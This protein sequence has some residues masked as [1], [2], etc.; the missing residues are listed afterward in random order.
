MR[1]RGAV[2]GSLEH[3]LAERSGE[4]FA[5][6]REHLNHQLV[7]I[8]QLTG[9]DRTYVSGS[10]SWLVDADGRRYLD[11]LSGF[12]TFALGRN[13]P[14]VKDALIEALQLD[15]PNLVQLDTPLPAGLL[16]ERLCDLAGPGL[17]RCFFGNSG[18]EAVE[19]AVK[20]A[21]RHTGRRRVLFCDHAFH[22][23]TTGALALNGGKDFRAGFGPLLPGTTR[24]PYGDV[25]AVEHQLRRGGVAALVVEPIQGKTMEVLDAA[26]LEALSE[27]CHEHGALLVVDEV[28]T[29]LGRTGAM[30]CYQHSR[31]R[32]DIATVAKALSGGFVPVSATL[33][34]DD[35]WRSTWR[36]ADRALVHSSTF[37]QGGL[38]MAAGLATLDVLED[39]G[40]V[41]HADRLGRRLADGLREL[42][43]RHEILIDVRGRGLMVGFELGPPASGVDRLAWRA[44]ELARR[45]L[46]AQLVVNPL[47]ERHRILTQVSADHLDVV[48]LLPAL[49]A[50]EP[51]VTCFLDALD[52]VLTTAASTG[53]A[54]VD[55][56]R[57]FVRRGRR[58]GAL[59]P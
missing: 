16:A 32:P 41:E 4:Q 6:H 49:V 51:E 52:E 14:A 43:A 12:G 56:V 18:A 36:S 59:R 58:T 17:D 29:G 23:L 9:F 47:F 30:F 21:R 34:R 13:H 57:G 31:V 24:V 55:L 42:Q 53:R 10:G 50:D 2:V 20:L 46:A 48:K 33:C 8:L 45:G 27:R 44:V 25:D 35:V 19:T 39:D 54:T 15:L 1:E 3:R 26:T 28:Q 11:L 40:L 38:A 37:G 5:L 7:R 22:G